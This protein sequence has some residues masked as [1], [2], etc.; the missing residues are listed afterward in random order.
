M[1]EPPRQ[2]R[3]EREQRPVLWTIGFGGATLD[4]ILPLVQEGRLPFFADLIESGAHARLTSYA[5]RRTSSLWTSLSTGMLPYRHGVLDDRVYSAPFIVPDRD[6]RLAPVGKSITHWGLL[7]A[8]IRRVDS[9]S[10]ET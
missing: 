3:V 2:A 7:G 6:L 1:A 10:S 4:A 5:P 8:P 9:S